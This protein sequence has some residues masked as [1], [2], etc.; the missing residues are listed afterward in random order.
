[1]LLM[2]PRVAVQKYMKIWA[3]KK[4]K[5]SKECVYSSIGPDLLFHSSICIG[6]TIKL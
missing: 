3:K 2:L 4:K 6:R 5:I 1:M